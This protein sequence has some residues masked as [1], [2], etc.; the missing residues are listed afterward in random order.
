MDSS[1]KLLGVHPAAA[2]Y[3][4]ATMA[5]EAQKIRAQATLSPAVYLQVVQI[6]EKESIYKQEAFYSTIAEAAMYGED[7]SH[8]TTIRDIGE[9]YAKYLFKRVFGIHG[10]W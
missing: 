7:F 2:P 8:V 5:R 9:V 3:I 6:V 1:W 4:E 10:E